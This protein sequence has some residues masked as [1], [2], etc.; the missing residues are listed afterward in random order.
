MKKSALIAVAAAAALGLAACGSGGGASENEQGLREVSFSALPILPTGAIVVGQEQ[1][2]FED[3]GIDLTVE[4]AQG[5]AAI[6]P[7]VVSG[8]PQFGTSNP[9]SLLTARDKGLPLKVLT[10]WSSDLMPPEDGINGIISLK[11]SGI[12]EPADLEGKSIAINTLKSIG[13]L[14]IRETLREAGGDPDSI[15]FVELGFPDMPAALEAGNVDAVWVPEPFLTSLQEGPGQLVGYTSQLSV[16]GMAMQYTF[17][18]EEL[19][20]SDPELVASMTA[21]LEQTLT[22]A[23]ENPDEVRA[24]AQELTGIPPELVEMAGLEAFG[25]DLRE[26]QL[27]RLGELMTDEGWIDGPADIDGL[28]P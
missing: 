8:K 6:I 28:L 9:V 7:G 19:I 22:Y 11:D 23:E 16:P 25:T 1:G 24:A 18:S 17:T 3:E 5:G 10:H 15:D 27:K 2:F 13:D 4:M 21:A 26:P 20:A 12:D 14:T